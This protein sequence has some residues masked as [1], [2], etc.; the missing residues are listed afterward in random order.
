[1][2][3][4]PAGRIYIEPFGGAASILLRRPPSPIEVYND[5]EPGI[6]D[7]ML[8]ARDHAAKL[9][10]RL[11]AI[12]FY[13]RRSGERAFEFYKTMRDDKAAFA[14][15]SN[16]DRAVATYVVL[17]MS[18]S[19]MGTAFAW[20]ERKRGG[21]PGDLH[22]WK[23]GL[24]NVWAVSARLQGVEILNTT[25]IEV[26]D[27]YSSPKSTAYCDPPYPHRTRVSRDA[28]SCEMSTADHVALAKALHRFKGKVVLSGRP[29]KLYD[30]RLYSDWRRIEKTVANNSSQAKSKPRTREV[31]WMN[32]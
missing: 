17:R 26:L 13:D 31:L 16:I 9:V 18:R 29:C 22:S 6:A 10:A 25:A 3:Q 19:G 14:T 24:E 4:I 8:L 5:L 11:S 23:T 2:P 12:E 1:V 15:L 30:R 27:R 21:E 32:F 28:Y 20:S 7:L